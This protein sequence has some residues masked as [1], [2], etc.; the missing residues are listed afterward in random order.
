PA[1]N[2]DTGER[3]IA[4]LPGRTG[5]FQEGVGRTI[6]YATALGCPQ[7]NCLIGISPTDADAERVHATLVNNLKFAADKLEAAGIRLLIEPVNDK[8]IPGFWLNHADQAIALFD[9]V[10]SKNVFL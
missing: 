3:G 10:G 5:E 8:D 4:C 6:E 9:E 7:V 1:G 2:W